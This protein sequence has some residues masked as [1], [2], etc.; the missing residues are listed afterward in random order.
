MLKF[1]LN[2]NTVVIK[3]NVK[4]A[5]CLIKITVIISTFY[6]YSSM[7]IQVKLKIKYMQL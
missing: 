3:K 2:Q 6:K 7:H 4:R 1:F 5:K